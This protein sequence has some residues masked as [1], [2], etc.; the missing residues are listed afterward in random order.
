MASG[1]AKAQIADRLW[2]AYSAHPSAQLREQLIE[3]HRPLAASLIRRIRCRW[4]EDLEQVALVGLM[5]AVDRFDPTRGIGFPTFAVP[6]ILGELKRYLRDQSRLVRCPR[7]LVDLRA[8]VLAKEQELTRR[9]GRSPTLT[10][11]AAALG[12]PL[13]RV[14]GSM[15]IEET[16]HPYSLD[17]LLPSR[18]NQ[19]PLALQECLGAEDPELETVEDRI[20]WGQVLNQLDPRL[21]K[22]MRLRYYDNLSQQETARRLGVSQMQISRLERRALD[23][24][25]S[26][27]AIG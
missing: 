24:L 22:V 10:E 27:V 5:K 8:A 25:R 17:D 15:T 9:F 7:S 13:D 18:E 26:Q 12:T 14:V 23:H 3:H 19:P 11:I 16:C 20:V 6:T 21:K 2:S 1:G 4:D